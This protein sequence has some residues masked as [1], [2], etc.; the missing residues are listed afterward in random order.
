MM[1]TAD[2]K[3][4]KQGEKEKKKKKSKFLLF[5]ARFQFKFCAQLLYNKYED[6]KIV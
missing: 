1:K 3:L 4:N 6:L 2:Q 5:L